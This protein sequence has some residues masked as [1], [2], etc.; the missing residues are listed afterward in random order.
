MSLTP[1]DKQ[2]IEHLIELDTKMPPEIKQYYKRLIEK[3]ESLTVEIKH[4]IWRHTRELYRI[5][6]LEER[7]EQNGLIP[8]LFYIAIVPFAVF[9]LWFLIGMWTASVR[10]F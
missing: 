4:N 5:Q 8:L 9:V 10:N 3:D 2:R 1:R 6:S 7:K